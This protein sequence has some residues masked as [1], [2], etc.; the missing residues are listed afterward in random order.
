MP[1]FSPKQRKLILQET[2]SL[3]DSRTP[4]EIRDM[5]LELHQK[6]LIHECGDLPTDFGRMSENFYLLSEC[7]KRMNNILK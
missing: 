4:S 1:Y 5:L 3:F 6:Y 7:L 2:E